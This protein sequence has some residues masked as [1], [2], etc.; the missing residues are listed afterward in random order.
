[1]WTRPAVPESDES[2][3]KYFTSIGALVTLIM[4]L[5]AVVVVTWQSYLQ[6]GTFPSLAGNGPILYGGVALGIILSAGYVLWGWARWRS[7]DD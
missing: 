5:L 2:R 6:W 7:H 3:S 1:M 4:L